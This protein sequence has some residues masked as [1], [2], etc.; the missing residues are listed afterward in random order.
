MAIESSFIL[1]FMYICIKDL[2]SA[3]NISR[4]YELY[5][6]AYKYVQYSNQL[7]SD[8]R[9]AMLS[10]FDL[11]SNVTFFMPSLYDVSWRIYTQVYSD[12][13]RNEYYSELFI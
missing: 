4:N 11:I 6:K 7:I 10:W 2:L 8:V 5:S 3:F 9:N 13:N 1:P 12:T